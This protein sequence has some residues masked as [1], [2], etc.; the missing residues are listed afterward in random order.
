MFANLVPEIPLK[1]IDFGKLIG[2]FCKV[3]VESV[4]VI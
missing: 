2:V 3:N 4:A 1:N